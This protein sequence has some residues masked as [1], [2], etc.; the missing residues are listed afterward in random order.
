[1]ILLDIVDVRPGSD[2]CAERNADDAVNAE[3]LEAAEYSLVLSRIV[4]SECRCN[5]ERNLNAL[6]EMPFSSCSEATH[7][8]RHEQTL[9]HLLQPTHLSLVNTND[10]IFS[11]IC[12]PFRAF[13]PFSQPNV[14]QIAFR[15]NLFC[16]L[17][18]I[19]HSSANVKYKMHFLFLT[20]FFSKT[21]LF[22]T[23][24]KKPW[25]QSLRR[26]ILPS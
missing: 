18:I 22:P 21:L 20:S 13:K 5:K 8:P 11:S 6:L 16:L 26:P 4:C 14:D 24:S 7:A 19:S 3:L 25:L 1:M 9:I 12:S 17:D 23:N 15:H 10:S 2:I